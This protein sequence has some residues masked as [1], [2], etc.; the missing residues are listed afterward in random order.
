MNTAH[1][2][3]IRVEVD[4]DGFLKDP[5]DWSEE[6]VGYFAA[7]EHLGPLTDNHWKV[8][9]YLRDYYKKFGCSPITRKLCKDTGCSLKELETLFSSD[10]VRAAYKLAGLPKPTG[11]R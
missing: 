1:A 2:E 6:I 10:C 11:C 3:K 4:D 8:I 5:E 7:Q 9:N